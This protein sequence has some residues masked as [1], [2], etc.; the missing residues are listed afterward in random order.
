MC[1]D[2]LHHPISKFRV[3][4]DLFNLWVLLG[5]LCLVFIEFL[6][7]VEGLIRELGLAPV[8]IQMEEHVL[9]LLPPVQVSSIPVFIFMGR[10]QL[11]KFENPSL[12]ILL[13]Q[14][15]ILIIG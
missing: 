14:M 12:L 6:N 7:K 1:G 5:Q 4:L 15:L 3:Q 10:M 8:L 2:S 9:E 11:D 13:Y